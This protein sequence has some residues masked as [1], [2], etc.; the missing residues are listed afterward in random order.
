MSIHLA[1]TLKIRD[2]L[3]DNVY[4][5]ELASALA[6][7]TA[8]YNGQRS[9]ADQIASLEAQMKTARLAQVAESTN[10]REILKSAARACE[11]VDSSDE[12]LA[13][14][15]WELRKGRSPS[16]IL[17][18][19]TRLSL[20]PTGFPGE[21]IARWSRVT[22]F[23]Y[24]ELQMAVQE[25]NSISPDWDLIPIRST[26]SASDTL[27][28]ATTGKQ[29]HLRVRTVS[30]KGPSPWSDAIVAIVL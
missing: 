30:A 12:A 7:L 13:S 9:L 24:Y 20:R 4:Y 8:S 11:S 23:R 26:T 21:M 1:L 29:M 5:P 3:T 6:A 18:T 15:G 14:V 22:N 27:P 2:G 28:R 19:P 16:Q 17:P 25:D 10:A